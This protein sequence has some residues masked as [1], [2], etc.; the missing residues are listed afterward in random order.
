[1]LK[2]CLL[3]PELSHEIESAHKETIELLKELCAIPAPSHHEERRAE[4]VRNW[5]ESHGL[6]AE[7]DDAKT[8]GAALRSMNIRTSSLLWRIWIP[9]FRIWRP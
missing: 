5:F 9:F 7:I 4:F 1:M 3:T 2:A 6:S 8:C